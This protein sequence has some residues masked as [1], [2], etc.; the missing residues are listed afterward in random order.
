MSLTNKALWII[1]RN[2]HRDLSLASIAEAA[3]VSRYHLAHAFGTATGRSV[4]EYARGR[5]LTEAARALA[6][7]APDIL[8]VA[9]E[10]GYASHE[11]FSRAFRAQFDITPEELR[12]KGSLEGLALVDAMRLSTADRIALEEPEI[13]PDGPLLFVGLSE[14]VDFANAP[15]LVPALWQRF[16]PHYESIPDKANPIP[17]GVTTN[18]DDDGN[19]DYVAAVEVKRFD[20]VRA[21]LVKVSVPRQTYAV[22]QHRGHISTV[23]QTFDAIWNDWLSFHGKTAADGPSLERANPGFDTMTGNGG[24]TLWVPLK[25]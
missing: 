13:V 24:E 2:L 12:R 19:F 10:A 4:M 15:R 11:A 14:R 23:G 21:P 25:G 1:E 20:E 9:L 5:R 7:G 3:G 22:F 8:A 18:L 17:V 16:M 6:T